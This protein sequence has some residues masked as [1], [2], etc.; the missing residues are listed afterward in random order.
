MNEAVSYTREELERLGSEEVIELYV[1]MFQ[2]QPHHK[3]S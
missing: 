3:K 1:E 2:K